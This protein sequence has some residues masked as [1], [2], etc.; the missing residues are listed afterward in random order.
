MLIL[1]F[2]ILLKIIQVTEKRSLRS[3]IFQL[4]WREKSLEEIHCNKKRFT[5]LSPEKHVL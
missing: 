2:S 4:D 1:P 3:R 5:V